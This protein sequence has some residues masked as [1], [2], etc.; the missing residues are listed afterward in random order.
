MKK[1]LSTT[2]ESRPCD[3]CARTILKGERTESYIGPEGQRYLVC[4][5]CGARAEQSGWIRESAHADL[6][7]H[8]KRS[9]PRRSLLGRLR[10]REE[11]EEEALADSNGAAPEDEYPES[12]GSESAPEERSSREER[13]REARHV[14][15]VPTNAEVKIERALE[16]F[17]SSEHQRTVAGL[18]RSLGIPHVSAMPEPEAPRE[19]TIIVAWELSWYRFRIDLGDDLEQ[20]LLQ[21]KGDELGE[22]EGEERDWNAA[23]DEAGLLV[24]SDGPAP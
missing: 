18:T 13:R 21:A 5:L 3:V 1:E 10:R 2:T 15:A 24:A 7:A 12:P 11:E 14:R 8:H 19:V 16:I 23:L 22:I 9:E 4:E 17:N 20:V 6:P